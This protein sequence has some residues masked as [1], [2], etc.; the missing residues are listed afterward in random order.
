MALDL[1]AT[2]GAT[3]VS[4]YNAIVIPFLTSAVKQQITCES[5]FLLILF[6]LCYS[7]YVIVLKLNKK[8]Y[9]KRENYSSQMIRIKKLKRLMKNDQK[10]IH[11]KKY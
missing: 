10:L 8:K 2:S 9:F 5:I 4:N 11:Y 6:S 3:R 7:V 1:V